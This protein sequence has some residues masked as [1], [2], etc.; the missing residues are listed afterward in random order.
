MVL[1]DGMRNRGRVYFGSSVS[2]VL[3][4]C[5]TPERGRERLGRTDG[6]V[7]I[8]ATRAFGRCLCNTSLAPI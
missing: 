4:E 2:L 5:S 6:R 8:S 1:E 3:E 7:V